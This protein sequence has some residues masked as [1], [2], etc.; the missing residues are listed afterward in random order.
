MRESYDVLADIFQCI[1]NFIGRLKIYT[2]IQPTPSMTE[3][4]IKIMVELLAV[5]A[6]ATRQINR[7][8]LSESPHFLPDDSPRT[9]L[10]AERFAKKLLGEEDIGQ[11]LQRLDRLTLEESK[12]AIAQTLDVVHSLVNNMEVVMD[13]ILWFPRYHV[14]DTEQNFGRWK[15]IN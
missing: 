5:L 1:E 11:V 14:R 8:R 15:S 13:G 7:G 9:G 12:V 10:T 2:E 6:L 4:I 3:T